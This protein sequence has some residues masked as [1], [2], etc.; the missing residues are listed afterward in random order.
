MTDLLFS[1]SALE[2][3]IHDI[4]RFN[5]RRII[6]NA[7][8]LEMA[9]NDSDFCDQYGL[10]PGYIS[11]LIKGHR[12]MGEKSARNIENSLGL[13]EKTLDNTEEFLNNT[14]SVELMLKNVNDFA[15]FTAKIKHNKNTRDKWVSV[16]R[17]TNIGADGFFTLEAVVDPK[18]CEG[19]VPSLT[20]SQKAYAIQASD[21]VYHPAIRDGWFVVCDPN[22]LPVT[23]EYILVNM[24][25]G[26]KIIQE[27]IIQ[28]GD[29][30]IL[31]D[32]LGV[33]RTSLNL[34]DIESVDP[35]IEIITPSRHLKNIPT[36]NLENLF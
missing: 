31:Q 15:S 18:I 9:K 1:N 4:R 19:F 27:F 22:A 35:V 7:R 11:Q 17:I 3:N 30:L 28:R 23:T 20:A 2:M 26:R 10:N 16:K 29:T 24:K 32:V 33:S 34:K 8:T 25:D 12:N 5:L 14:E 21:G 6:D 36:K 13:A